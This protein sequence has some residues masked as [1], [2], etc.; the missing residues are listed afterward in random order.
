MPTIGSTNLNDTASAGKLTAA[1][2][3]SRA[4][5]IPRQRSMTLTGAAPLVAIAAGT[6][7]FGWLARLAFFS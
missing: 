6:A 7:F 5:R 1:D 2:F 4:P 3:E